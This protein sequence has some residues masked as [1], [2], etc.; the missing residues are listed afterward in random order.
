MLVVSDKSAMWQCS[1][2]WSNGYK[3]MK[4]HYMRSPVQNIMAEIAAL[5]R[6]ETLN[7]STASFEEG[8]GELK[9]Q[10]VQTYKQN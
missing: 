9:V 2:E 4:R 8:E 7:G 6:H 3:I 1:G 5:G 10:F